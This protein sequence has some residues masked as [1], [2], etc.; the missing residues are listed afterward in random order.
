MSAASCQVCETRLPPQKAGQRRLYCPKNCRRKVEKA[1]RRLSKM[2]AYRDELLRRASA[3]QVAY[4]AARRRHRVTPFRAGTADEI[5]AD[6]VKVEAR[7]AALAKSV[8]IAWPPERA[9]G[10]L[11]S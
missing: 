9:T 3:V 4:Q 5:R 11:A 7:M 10:R 6:A 1:R 2:A 8:G